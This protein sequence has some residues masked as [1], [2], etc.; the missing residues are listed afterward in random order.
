MSDDLMTAEGIKREQD[1]LVYLFQQCRENPTDL[2]RLYTLVGKVTMLLSFLLEQQ[3]LNNRQPS[4]TTEQ[5]Q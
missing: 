1:Y 5:K 3:L 2:N 4:E